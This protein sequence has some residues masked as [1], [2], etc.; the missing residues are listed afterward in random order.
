VE[1]RFT[2]FHE[3]RAQRGCCQSARTINGHR[4]FREEASLGLQGTET[5]NISETLMATANHE[6]FLSA[7]VVEFPSISRHRVLALPGSLVRERGV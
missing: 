2:G 4:E 6:F 1:S 7:R 3:D 5:G